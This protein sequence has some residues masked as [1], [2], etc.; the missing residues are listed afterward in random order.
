M[1]QASALQRWG[2]KILALLAYISLFFFILPISWY[3]FWFIIGVLCGV[4]FLIADEQFLYRKYQEK[5]ADRFLVTRSPLFLLSL[6][7]L[8]VFVLTSS[9]SFWA[10]GVMGGMMLLL[11][12]EMTELRRKPPEFDQR[13]LS[14][15]KGEVSPQHIQ[16]IL[17][18]GWSF[19]ALI[20]LLVML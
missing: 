1:Q 2:L 6:I 7:P 5:P 8:A 16:V 4:G 3:L 19:F 20:H 9:G 13:F 14:N 18:S 15:I 17:L 11:L 10:N 12:L